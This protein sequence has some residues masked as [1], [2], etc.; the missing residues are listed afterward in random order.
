MPPE[1]DRP[2]VLLVAPQAFF[3]A[4]GT[5]FNVLRMCQALGELGYEVHLA[6]FPHG[7]DVAVPGT[8]HHRTPALPWV[9]RVPVGFSGA[10][11]CY[12][13]LLAGLT[14]RLLSRHRFVAVQAVEEAAFFAV[15]L[16]RLFRT[17][18][19]VDLDS[20]ICRQL[21]DHP[22]ALAR[23]LGRLAGP[24]RRSVLRGAAA[25]VT[26]ARHLSELVAREAP[27][28][29]VFE[30]RDIPLPGTLRP[31]EPAAMTRLRAELDLTGRRV[32]AYTGNFDRRQGLDLLLDAW[33]GVASSHPDAV[34]LL[35]GGEPAEV[36]AMRARAQTL[37]VAGSVRLAGKRP[38]ELMA[39]IMGLAEVLVSPRLEPYVTPLKLYSYMASGRPIVATDLPT[40]NTVL[41]E[42]SAIL[43]PPTAEGLAKGI[44]QALADSA[45]AAA[46]GTRA[47]AL[48]ESEYSY[49][50]FRG[51][52]AEL[53]RHLGGRSVS[54]QGTGMT[55][56]T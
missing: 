49:A 35:V 21:A 30:I 12:D 28:L 34:L 50:A 17:P 44:A 46:L 6:T 1:A 37:G 9:R 10:K 27:G 40:H 25:A 5:P 39:D 56:P 16:A 2:R 45:A 31:P 52:M 51:R 7:E 4:T 55:E 11:V 54:V 47:K 13:F 36:A 18:A 41:D 53:Y 33:V 48:V 8:I 3:A 15:P 42:T 29:P 19:V 20:D 32:V 38:A 23:R 43:V 22:S 26:V 14:F 24:L